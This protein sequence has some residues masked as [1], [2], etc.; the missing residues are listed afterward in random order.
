MYNTMSPSLRKTQSGIERK[1]TGEKGRR[2]TNKKTIIAA[3]LNFFCKINQLVPVP[4]PASDLT[5]SIFA[6]SG[7]FLFKR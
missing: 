4:L 7:I 6:S 3:T 1:G 2:L 5:F